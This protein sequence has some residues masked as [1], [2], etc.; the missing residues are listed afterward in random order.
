MAV[1]IVRAV[2]M[3]IVI[4]TVFDTSVK[5]NYDCQGNHKGSKYILF[6]FNIFYNNSI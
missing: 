1:I 5:R 6:H 4:I 2:M 3:I